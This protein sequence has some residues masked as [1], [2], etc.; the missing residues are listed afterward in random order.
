MTLSLQIY[1]SGR[2]KKA[3]LVPY[4]GDAY[5]FVVVGER[6]AQKGDGKLVGWGFNVTKQL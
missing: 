2:Y 5:L 3:H 6:R 4:F 1:L